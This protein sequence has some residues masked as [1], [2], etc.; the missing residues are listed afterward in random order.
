MSDGQMLIFD[1]LENPEPIADVP[2]EWSLS[3]L[4]KHYQRFKSS[5]GL[6]PSFLA[7]IQRHLRY[8]T[9]WL[10]KHRWNPDREKLS[11]MSTLLLSDYRLWLADNPNIGVSTANHYILHVR[12]LCKWAEDVHGLGPVRM[13]C[14]KPF[15]ANRKAKSG[16]GRKQHRDAIGW[17]ELEKLF[18]V[19]DV[20]DTSLLLL[21]LNC[22]F[23][24]MDIG[25]LK[26]S[27]VDLDA[28]TVSHCRSKTGVQRDFYLWPQT[29]SVL[30][31][32]LKHYR[33]TPAHPQYADHLFIGKRGH[34][35]CWER[36][37]EDGKFK[38]SDAIKSRFI[39][40]YEKASLKRPYGRGYYSLRHTF[41]TLI[42]IDSHDLREVQAALGHKTISMQQCYRH[43]QKGKAIAAQKRIQTVFEQSSI[44]R[45]VSEKCG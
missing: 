36:I 29:V 7:S 25:T 26:R 14:I 31:K 1:L 33:G 45:I 12:M 27:D 11:D 6:S 43:D 32:Y 18:R 4:I 37:D 24:N 28:A 3:R 17:D 35:F 10:K 20:V 8:F 34:P 19:A 38:R 13:G 21:G 22:G 9:D 16:H 2:A 40:L 42:G 23:G 15:S 5:E 39:R 44:P 30:R 41:A